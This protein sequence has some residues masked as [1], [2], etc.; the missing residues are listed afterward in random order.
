MCIDAISGESSKVPWKLFTLCN[1]AK[2]AVL[3]FTS[4][5]FCWVRRNA[6]MVAHFLAKFAS[7]QSSYFY[8]NSSNL[9]PLI[10]EA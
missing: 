7:S 9:P 3:D 1:N 4:C 6:N 2:V 10:H 5:S 8:C